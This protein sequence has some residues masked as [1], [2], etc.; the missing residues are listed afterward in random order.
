ML[1]L[2]C[3]Y[4]STVIVLLVVTLLLTNCGYKSMEWELLHTTGG[5]GCG[6]GKP[7]VVVIGNTNEIGRISVSSRDDK[8]TKLIET[9]YGES[10]VVA[11]YRNELPSGGFYLDTQRVEQ[12][13]KTMRITV[14]LTDPGPRT[15]VTLLPTCP[16]QV[17]RIPRTEPIT[18]WE[19]WTTDGELL[20]QTTYP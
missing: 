6:L 2:Q 10:W 16:Y 4:W 19:V 3:H 13:D 15:N 20:A 5:G 9:N 7:E 1:R 8:Y 12:G 18:H 11:V 14:K 17:L